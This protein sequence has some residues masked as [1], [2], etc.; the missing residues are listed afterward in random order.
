MSRS[1][2]AVQVAPSYGLNQ[3]PDVA[4]QAEFVTTLLPSLLSTVSRVSQVPEMMSQVGNR[5]R[6][7]VVVWVDAATVSAASWDF[8]VAAEG[9]P[10]GVALAAAVVVT[11]TPAVTRIA[12]AAIRVRLPVT[13]PPGFRAGCP[14]TLSRTDVVTR[15]DT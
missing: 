5:L 12:A 11:R 2:A 1:D 3:L 4:W 10:G 13:G 6:S 14:S 7:Y 8:A 15:V 9:I